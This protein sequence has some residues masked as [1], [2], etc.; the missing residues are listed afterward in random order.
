ML[1]NSDVLPDAWRKSSYSNGSGGD[2]VEVADG[3]PGLVPVRDS[4]QAG[5]PVLAFPEEQWTT[6]LDFVTR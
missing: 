5:G 2:C 3:V 4:K 1:R 6:F